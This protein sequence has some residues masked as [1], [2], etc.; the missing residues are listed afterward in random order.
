MKHRTVKQ[1]QCECGG[2]SVREKVNEGDFG[3]VYGWTSYTY[4][5]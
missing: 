4:M 3:K 5:K 2:T 1:V